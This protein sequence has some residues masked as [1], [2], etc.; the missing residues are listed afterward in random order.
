MEPGVESGEEGR[1]TRK[2]G[3]PMS[4]TWTG[5]RR[6][7]CAGRAVN[8]KWNLPDKILRHNCCR[9]ERLA[10]LVP[11]AGAAAPTCAGKHVTPGRF[12]LNRQQP[13]HNS[14]LPDVRPA[15]A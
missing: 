2:A 11:E 7:C 14:W 8:T 15:H 13:A 10:V 4:R 5:L 1:C 9:P 6:L 12:P 3:Y